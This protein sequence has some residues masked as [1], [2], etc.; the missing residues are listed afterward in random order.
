MFIEPLLTT[1]RAPAERNVS[2]AEWEIEHVS[3]R[4]SDEESLGGRAFYKHFVPMGRGG[5][6]RK[7]LSEK[8]EVTNLVGRDRRA[9]GEKSSLY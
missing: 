6:A 5:C 2:G 1:N 3:L 4:W 9:Y 8:Q 7:T